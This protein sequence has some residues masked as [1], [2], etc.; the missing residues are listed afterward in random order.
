MQGPGLEGGVLGV[1]GALGGAF[2]G[3]MLRRDLVRRHGCPDWQIAVSEDVLA[4]ALAVWSISVISS[5]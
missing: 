4:I 3:Y 1:A 5:T 2:G